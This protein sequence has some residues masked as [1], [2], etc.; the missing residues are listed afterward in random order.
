MRARLFIAV[1]ALFWLAAAASAQQKP[2]YGKSFSLELGTGLQPLHMTFIP[3][4]GYE[5]KL[6]DKGQAVSSEG[7]FYPV[8]SLTGVMR[9]RPKT[10]FTASAGASWYHHRN[11]QCSVFGTDPEGKPRY[12]LNDWTYTEW[13]DSEPVFTFTFQ[14]RHLYNPQNAFVL[15]TAIG[16]GLVIPTSMEIAPVPS[17]TP[18]AFRYGGRHFYGFAEFTLGPLAGLVHGGLGWS[19]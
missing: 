9:T 7:S 15:Y 3:S 12:N 19:F 2:V 16:A 8:L 17:L 18:I 13:M 14:W 1:A 5:G 6:A 10:E 4:Y 11:K